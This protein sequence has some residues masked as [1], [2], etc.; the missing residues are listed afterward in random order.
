MVLGLHHCISNCIVMNAM[1]EFYPDAY[2]EFWDMAETQNIS[3]PKGVCK[4]IDSDGFKALY[5]ATI[6]HQ[7]PLT[8]ALGE[9]Y[10]SILTLE[11]VTELFKRM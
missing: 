8:N 10:K 7:K 3:I 6:I 9:N 11:K 5:D 1:V 4:G 2:K